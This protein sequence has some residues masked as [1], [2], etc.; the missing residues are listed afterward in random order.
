VDAPK[1]RNI[2]FLQCTISK[3][4]LSYLLHDNE[5]TFSF[6][7]LRFNEFSIKNT[8]AMGEIVEF[9]FNASLGIMPT[10]I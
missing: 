3:H 9:A 8:N 4:I 10:H 2:V 6:T 1:L 7:T 5:P